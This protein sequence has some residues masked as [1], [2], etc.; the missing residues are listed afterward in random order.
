MTTTTILSEKRGDLGRRRGETLI[1]IMAS[2]MVLCIGL[3]GVLA[4]IPFGGFRMSQMSEADNSAAVGRN[5]VRMMKVNGW[6]N[7]K[8]WIVNNPFAADPSVTYQTVINPVVTSRNL[9]S[10][11]FDTDGKTH[12]DSVLDLTYPFVLDPLG[13]QTYQPYAS[14]FTPGGGYNLPLLHVC[15]LP[16]DD[17]GKYFAPGPRLI[18]WY[19]HNFY[20]QDDL[21]A[22]YYETE[23]D[24]EFRPRVETESKEFLDGN[25]SAVPSFSGRYSWMAFVSPRSSS[26]VIDRCEV[27]SMTSVDFDTVVFRDRIIGDEK[28]F[29]AQVTG[30]GY[31][32]GVVTIHLSSCRDSDNNVANSPEDY[33]RVREQ[34]L[35]TRY[36]LLAGPDDYPKA[37]SFDKD[38]AVRPTK[39]CWY[40]IANFANVDNETIRLTLIG[41]N[42]PI[43]WTFEG[44]RITAVFYP[45]VI[46]VYSGSAAF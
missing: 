19:E 30:S 32:G 4:A 45:G 43:G 44:A 11:V 41:P 40:K 17:G 35:Q 38:K 28:A 46:G 27:S 8:S 21:I 37:V 10:H 2:I 3:V 33:A 36:I 26:S 31:Q 29:A 20:Q 6:G 34:L 12:L 1:E 23:D 25:S 5:A 15:P 42:T 22:G 39:A 9:L 16:Q 24:T 18:S 13:A 14:A 7:P